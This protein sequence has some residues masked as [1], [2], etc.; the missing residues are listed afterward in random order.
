MYKQR[1]KKMPGSYKLKM[2]VGGSSGSGK[3]SFLLGN[4]QIDPEFNHLGVSFKPIECVINEVDSYKFIVWDLKVKERFGFLYPIFCKGASA[5][6]ICFD[7]SNHKSF[8]EI[9]YW[10]EIFRNNEKDI[11]VKIP[12]ILIGTKTD[13]NHQEVLE[14][15]V[16][17]LIKKYDL[18]GV[19]YTSIYD[20]DNKEKKEA[21]FKCLIEKIEPFCHVND[22]S[23]FIPKEDESFKKFVK[24]FATCPICK[25][26][27][28]FQSLKNFYFSREPTVVKLREHVLELISKSMNFDDIYYN[29][30]SVG[31]PCCSCFEKHFS[32]EKL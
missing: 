19:F 22:C 7:T 12:I 29:K 24:Q 3:T 2:V 11:E 26:N 14:E 15:E 1:F 31:I 18:E 27:N 30:I 5:A 13:L 10:V 9:A 6:F 28:H 23:I 25:R 16:N 4:T 32:K 20:I 8:K 21:I 17:D